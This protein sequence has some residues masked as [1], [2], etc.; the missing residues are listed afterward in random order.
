MTD[1]VARN[2]FEVRTRTSEG[3]ERARL[4]RLTTGIYPPYDDYQ[5]TAAGRQIPVVVLGS[6]E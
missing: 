5:A 4:W 2:R 3:E 6:M 1:L